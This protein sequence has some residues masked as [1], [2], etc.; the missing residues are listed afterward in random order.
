MLRKLTSKKDKG[1]KRTSVQGAGIPYK[2]L[3]ENG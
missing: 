2:D 3:S 1:H